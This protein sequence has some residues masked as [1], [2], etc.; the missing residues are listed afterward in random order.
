MSPHGPGHRVPVEGVV[1][2]QVDQGAVHKLD[3]RGREVHDVPR[4]VHRL[5]EAGEMADAEHPVR[6]DGLQVQLEAGEE[7]Q[8]ALR[9]HQQVAEI[10]RVSGQR[11]DVVAADAAH[12][13]GKA[14]GGL[15]GLALS[16]GEERLDQP[17]L[18]RRRGL[19]GLRA[20]L[21]EAQSAA[22]GQQRLDAPHVVAHGP[23]ADRACAAGIVARHA[24]QR[25]PAAGRGVHREEQAVRTQEGVEP[26]QHQ[27]RLH[28]DPAGLRVEVEDGVQVLADIDDQGPAD[29][30]SALRG[31]AARGRTATPASR[32]I[33]MARTTSSVVRGTTHADGLDL[34][35]RGVGRIA[36]AAEGVEQDLAFQ[37]APEARGQRR[38]PD[39]GPHFTC[40]FALRGFRPRKRLRGASRGTASG[41][42]R[43][44]TPCRVAMAEESPRGGSVRRVVSG[45][46]M[47]TQHRWLE[48]RD[49]MQNTIP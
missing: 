12:E 47:S 28:G 49:C 6:R 13:L 30:L 15:A 24:A 32:A 39:A 14:P 43:R 18:V 1:A 44:A 29:G 21:A 16:Q 26:V 46:D 22:V 17:W 20:Q 42:R 45:S 2:G 5:V 35:V 10:G 48:D 41:H 33:W 25:R 4:H 23:V 27:A 11:V 3:R 9:T 38:V 19:T 8:R 37:L 31:A 34:V 36:P 40:R 7:G